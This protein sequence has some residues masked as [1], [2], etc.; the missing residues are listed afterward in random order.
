MQVRNFDALP[1]YVALLH[2]H[3][4]SHHSGAGTYARAQALRPDDVAVLSPKT[5]RSIHGRRVRGAQY[6]YHEYNY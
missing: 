2:G 5:W 3:E 1:P 4:R 6:Y